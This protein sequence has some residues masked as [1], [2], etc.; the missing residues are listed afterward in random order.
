M[1]RH[2]QTAW[3]TVR[4]LPRQNRMR[5]RSSVTSA[6]WTPLTHVW[7]KQASTHDTEKNF[8]LHPCVPQPQAGPAHAWSFGAAV[9]TLLTIKLRCRRPGSIL[10]AC[11][12]SAS[13]DHS[14][15]R[16]KM[17]V[18]VSKRASETPREGLRRGQWHFLFT[19]FSDSTYPLVITPSYQHATN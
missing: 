5:L 13:G 1:V 19:S 8:C 9:G 10:L 17:P 2:C 12:L 3:S 6:L 15:N 18:R 14:T 7:V 16:S 11:F 4:H